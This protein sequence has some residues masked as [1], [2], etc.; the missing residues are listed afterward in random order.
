MADPEGH[1]ARQV[2]F[3][4]D[5]DRGYWSPDSKHFAFHV[6]PAFQDYVA[7][8]DAD[9]LIRQPQG[10]VP[11]IRPVVKTP[12]G[13]MGPDWSPD[14]KYLYTTRPGATYR[15]MRVPSGGGEVED[16]FEGDGVRIEP[17]AR[18]I[19]Y[20]KAG[21][22]GLFARS[23]DGDVRLNPEERIISDFV[24]PRGF[25]V[26]SRGIYYVGRDSAR[27]PVAIRFFDFSV[28]KSFDI[29]PAPLGL[30]PSIAISPDS[31]RLLYDTLSDSVG[32]LALI[33]FAQR[34]R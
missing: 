27:R 30:T 13:M 31:K 34:S 23:L 3:E 9:N 26:N 18:R 25:D 20:G 12:F 5:V 6:S 2:T 21:I 11:T 33:K 15:I 1:N 24:A 32:S 16:L 8:I 17:A 7:D 28:R 4:G 29:A 22:V 14:Q 10:A 19:F